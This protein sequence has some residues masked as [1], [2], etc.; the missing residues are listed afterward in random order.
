MKE[1]AIPA[2]E[3]G[4]IIE[5]I[6][7]EIKI[8]PLMNNEAVFTQGQLGAPIQG[9]AGVFL[10][11]HH[12]LPLQKDIP[13]LHNDRE[14]LHLQ[15]IATTSKPLTHRLEILDAFDPL[16]AILKDNI[17]IVVWE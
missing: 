7:P 3:P 1:F 16:D 6:P 12:H 14:D 9:C 2:V 8:I 5:Y 11:F 15:S 4:D 13:G 17:L 10:E